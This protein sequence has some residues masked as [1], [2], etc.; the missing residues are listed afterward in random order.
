MKLSDFDRVQALTY[1]RDRLVKARDWLELR[2]GGDVQ[3]VMTWLGE[4][5]DGRTAHLPASALVKAIDGEI[6]K[7]DDE[8]RGLGVVP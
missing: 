5:R 7:C 8:L 4:G 6:D 3:A 2:P 1:K